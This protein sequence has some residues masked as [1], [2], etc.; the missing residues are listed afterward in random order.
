MLTP[1][2]ADANILERQEMSLTGL[3][4]SLNILE[5]LVLIPSTWLKRPRIQEEKYKKKEPK[6]I[7]LSYCYQTIRPKL[8]KQLPLIT[9]LDQKLDKV[10]L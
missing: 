3:L 7:G 1:L 2:L 8:K 6:L 4:G 10:F 9:Y 5:R